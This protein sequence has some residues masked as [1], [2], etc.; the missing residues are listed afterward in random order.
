MLAFARQARLVPRVFDLIDVVT[1][2]KNWT[3]RT[4]PETIDVKTSLLP[5]LWQINADPSS[6]ESALLNL[7][8]NARDAMPKGGN[9]TNETTNIQIDDEYLIEN[10]E[11]IPHGRYVMLTVSDTGTGI[12]PEFLDSIFNPFFTTKPPGSGSG[13]GLSMI[14]GFTRQSGGSVWAA[15]VG[16]STPAFSKTRVRTARNGWVFV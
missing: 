16:V 10:G 8:L 14:E 11:E 9:L 2:T 7:I 15:F 12:P 5:G 1:R 6:T 4:L 13:L 3:G